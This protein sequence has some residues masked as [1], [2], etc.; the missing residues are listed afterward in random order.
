[1]HIKRSLQLLDWQNL[2][3]I[4]GDGMK[5]FPQLFAEW[6]R[7]QNEPLLIKQIFFILKDK[8][9]SSYPRA[10]VISQYLLIVIFASA[11]ADQPWCDKARLWAHTQLPFLDHR[12]S[13]PFFNFAGKASAQILGMN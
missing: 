13:C 1:M 10:G 11:L 12:S 7:S 2:K 8:S 4:L 6:D 3:I 5:S 9:L